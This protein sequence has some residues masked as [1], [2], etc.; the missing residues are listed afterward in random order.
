METQQ[1]V[2][3]P[4]GTKQWVIINTDV[5]PATKKQ[6]EKIEKEIEEKK[7][8]VEKKTKKK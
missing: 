5:K 7:E 3:M 8:V 1:L 2:R 4:D 6:A